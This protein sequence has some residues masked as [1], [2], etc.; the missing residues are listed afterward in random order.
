MVKSPRARFLLAA[1]PLLLGLLLAG[2][3]DDEPTASRAVPDSS[4][5]PTGTSSVT[6]AG[7][8]LPPMPETAR[9]ATPAGAEAFVG[10]WVDVL[11]ASTRLGESAELRRL[12]PDCVVCA[13]M[14]D[15]IEGLA[16]AG[17]QVTGEGW[18]VRRAA[19]QPRPTAQSTA[20][21]VTVLRRPEAVVPSTGAEPQYYEG[22]DE[23]YLM[24]VA[25]SGD[26]WRL[27]ELARMPDAP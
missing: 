8:L 5:T 18:L 19:L 15:G 7:A 13:K 11:N 14:A 3:S 17:G 16:A 4:H 20:F 23:R 25:R 12:G 6:S 10:H 21:V 27:V 1:T 26:E 9:E 24:R 2:C 22:G